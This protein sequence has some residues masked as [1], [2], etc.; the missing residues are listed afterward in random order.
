MM[1][2]KVLPDLAMLMGLT[3]TVASLWSGAGIFRPRGLGALTGRAAGSQE[4]A[5][6]GWS[7][8]PPGLWLGGCGGLLGRQMQLP[9]EAVDIGPGR[10]RHF[11]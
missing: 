6:W 2:E 1:N 10:T 5:S 8:F 11:G 3:V 4:A 7:F 9:W